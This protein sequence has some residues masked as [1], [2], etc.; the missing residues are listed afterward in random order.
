M[1]VHVDVDQRLLF[2]YP[3]ANQLI[4]ATRKGQSEIIWIVVEVFDYLFALKEVGNLLQ[5]HQILIPYTPQTGTYDW[6]W[7]T[8]S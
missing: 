5:C 6:V 2:D 7:K 8:Y 4:V 3:S 1:E